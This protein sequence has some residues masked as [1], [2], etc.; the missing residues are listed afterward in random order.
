MRYVHL[1]IAV[2]LATS[3]SANS[4]AQIVQFRLET[5]DTSG[6]AID[7]VNVGEPFLLQTFVQQVGAFQASSPDDAG[8]FAAYLDVNYEAELA[9]VSGSV[10]YSPT[11]SNGKSGVLSPG[12]M[13]NIGA[14]AS[15]EDP[16]SLPVPAGA[17]EQFLFSVPM[18]ADSI[19]DLIFV[20][21]ESL[22]YP[23]Y[24]V[25]VWTSLEPVPAQE[26]DFGDASLRIDFGSTSLSVVPEPS[27][28]GSLAL[29]G[30]GALGLRRRRS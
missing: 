17:E 30:V 27:G 1:M 16:L 10:N 20:G 7:S 24:E 3:F 6:N 25:L 12:F 15:S 8:V 19:G 4:F 5:T 14:F 18:T 23:Q 13:D 21:S 9:S 22:T 29:G 26:I 11:Y 28:L 2:A